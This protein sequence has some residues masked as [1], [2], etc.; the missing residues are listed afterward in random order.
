[1][2]NDLDELK[3]YEIIGECP[4]QVQGKWKVPLISMFWVDKKNLYLC[5]IDP[6]GNVSGY[7]EGGR[8]C[9]Q[10]EDNLVELRETDRVIVFRRKE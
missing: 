1:M 4:I 6:K 5:D 9:L 7:N 3:K 2:V 8:Y 10:L